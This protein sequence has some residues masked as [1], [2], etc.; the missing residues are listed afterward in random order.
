MPRVRWIG[1]RPPPPLARALSAAGIELGRSGATAAVICAPE[2]PAAPP[3][4]PWIWVCPRAVPVDASIGAVLRG[5]YEVMA[6]AD[7]PAALPARL[8]EL[9]LPPLDVPETPEFVAR[10]P[11][12]RRVLEQIARAARTSMPVLLTGET[13]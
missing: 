3:R 6:L 13:G 12:G 10:G 7:A 1:R 9:A 4:L 11:A 5:A 2:L 8:R